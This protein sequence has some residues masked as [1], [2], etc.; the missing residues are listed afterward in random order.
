MTQE[1]Y[2][3]GSK[4]KAAGIQETNVADDFHRSE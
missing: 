3:Y 2:T 4:D 1:S